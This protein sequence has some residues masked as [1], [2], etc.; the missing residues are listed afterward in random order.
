MQ[1]HILTDI[2]KPINT[3]SFQGSCTLHELKIW[4]AWRAFK[5]RTLLSYKRDGVT[6][7]VPVVPGKR[8]TFNDLEKIAAEIINSKEQVVNMYFNNGRVTWTLY[9]GAKNTTDIKW[10]DQII[11]I[12]GL[13]KATPQVFPNVTILTGE[14]VSL[15]DINFCF[16]NAQTIYLTSDYTKPIF[17]NNQEMKAIVGTPIIA[18]MNGCITIG[19]FQ[20][21]LDFYTPCKELT[22]CIKDENG[23]TL[24]YEKIFIRLQI[25]ECL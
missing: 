6:C 4:P 16:S 3:S 18:D 17:V 14:P 7:T 5:F 8:Y 12:L 21:T 25:N 2:S 23:I 15:I 1:Q 11:K 20:P 19:S 22:F 9:K 10:N 13:D 24:P